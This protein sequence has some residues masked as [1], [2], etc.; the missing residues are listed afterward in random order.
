MQCG[1]L[2]QE[3]STVWAVLSSNVGFLQLRERSGRRALRRA[4][5]AHDGASHGTLGVLRRAR[6][7]VCATRC[8]DTGELIE[9]LTRTRARSRRLRLAHFRAAR[10]DV[11][12]GL[13]V[14]LVLIPQ[15]LAYAQLAGMPSYRGLYAAAL[16]PIAAA[17]F[18][19]S[20]YLQTGPV[21]LTSL[22][23]FGVL[24][25]VATPGSDEYVQ[26]GLLLALIVGVVRL[27][28][29]LLN[30][31]VIAY[32]ISRPLLLGFMPAVAILIVG[33]Q[34][35]AALGSS[36]RGDGIL[37]QAAWAVVHP[38]S[39]TV[40]AVV[41]SGTVLVLMAAGRRV[42]RL[43]PSVLLAVAIGIAY[44]LLSDY[45]GATVGSVPHTLPPI[46]VAFPWGDLP[47]L[48]VG[49]IVI[50]LV[51]FIEPSSIARTFATQE[52][53]RWDANREFLGQG[54]A[55]VAAGLSGGFPVGGSFSR[56]A[57]NRATGART[58]WSGAITGLAILLFLPFAGFLS[59]LP[60]AV[61]AGIVIGSVT[62]L[63]RPLPI[64][65]LARFSRPQFGVA[66]ATF[67]LTLVLAPRVDQAA[68]IAIALS[69]AIHLWRELSIEV[70]SWTEAETLHLRPRGVLWFGSA[71][72]LEDVFVEL[73]GTHPDS[74]HLVIHLDGVGR[75]DTTAALSLRS[76]VYDARDAGL[77]AEFADVRPRWRRLVEGVIERAQDPLGSRDRKRE[78]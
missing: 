50:A 1:A 15:S 35:P 25:T 37:A 56:S 38:S 46:S 68:L 23:A 3:L 55:N 64:L 62:G 54:A 76:L 4:G 32:L 27:A 75:I 51:G 26:F 18:A 8:C 48:L 57:L 63:I 5:G 58:R 9:P 13:S 7:D 6:A 40:Q 2:G 61:L 36:P 16:P 45:E 70:P 22:L 19:S 53:R 42:H 10:G 41:L 12:A 71:A 30:A 47:A 49:G 34:L 21:A 77:T 39:W 59:T 28:V 72:R 33:T 29:G 65:R 11:I 74:R 43:F 67:V 66:V 52:R 60:I 17:I 78:P 31:G 14:A 20:P 69:V 73:L 44:S 24:S